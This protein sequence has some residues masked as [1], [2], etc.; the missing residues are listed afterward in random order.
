[1]IQLCFADVSRADADVLDAGVSLLAYRDTLAQSEAE[2]LRAARSLLALLRHGRTYAA[3]IH[4]VSAPVLLIHGEQDR[5]VPVEAARRLA[6]A[7]PE[8]TT[9]WLAGVG[10]TPQ[11]E[12]P[13][14]FHALALPFL[15]GAP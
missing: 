6:A 7:R 11:L 3:L 1:M 5:L 12:E 15:R 13:D 14:A 8:W 4:R 2:F 10:H 9:E